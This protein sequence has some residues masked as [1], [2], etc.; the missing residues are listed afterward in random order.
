MK[1]KIAAVAALVLMSTAVQAD[2]LKAATESVKGSVM[3]SVTESTTNAKDAAYDAAIQSALG[4]TAGKTSKSYVA[5]KL[6]AAQ[7]TLT[8]NGAEVWQYDFSV[9]QQSY[10]VLTELLK[11]YPQVPAAIKLGFKED[12]VQDIEII[13][14]PA[15]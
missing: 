11:Q 7:Q 14:A 15:K 8:E 1:M 4:L 13:K 10:P 9:L 6:G 3:D 12:V 5:E 2:W